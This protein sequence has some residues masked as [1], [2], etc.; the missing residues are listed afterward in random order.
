ML[1]LKGARRI[2]SFTSPANTTNPEL[3][4]APIHLILA[5]LS[6]SHWEQYDPRNHTIATKNSCTNKRHN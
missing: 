2:D 3:P 1:L 5:D 4:R 6:A